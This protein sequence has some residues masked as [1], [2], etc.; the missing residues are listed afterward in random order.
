MWKH[1][2]SET[3]TAA[4]TGLETA[5]RVQGGPKYTVLNTFCSERGQ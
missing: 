5:M 3:L 2:D 1:P 4:V